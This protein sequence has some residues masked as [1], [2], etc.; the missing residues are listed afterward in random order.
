MWALSSL[1]FL[2]ATSSTVV[3]GSQL[4]RIETLFMDGFDPLDGTQGALHMDLVPGRCNRGPVGESASRS[5][6]MDLGISA[7]AHH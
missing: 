7:T 2:G 3:Y 1:S 4:E 5:V 6:E